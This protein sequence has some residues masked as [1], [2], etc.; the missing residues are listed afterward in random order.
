M[1]V[2]LDG[3]EDSFLLHKVENHLVVT[4]SPP[5]S[6][7]HWSGLSEVGVHSEA[8]DHKLAGRERSEHQDYV[9]C[10]RGVENLGKEMEPDNLG[11]FST[12]DVV[13]ET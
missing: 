11:C 1:K 3:E 9:E 7:I 6:I 4:Q 5:L 10:G 12:C 8:D 13:E 2:F